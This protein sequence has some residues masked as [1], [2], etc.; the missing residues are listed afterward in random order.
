MKQSAEEE[1]A[2]ER[3]LEERGERGERAVRYLKE[4]ACLVK[5]GSGESAMH[6]LERTRRTIDPD[7]TDDIL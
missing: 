4:L 3:R 1:A 5:Y 7:R 2:S 6:L